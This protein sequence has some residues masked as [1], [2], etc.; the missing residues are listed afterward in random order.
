MFADVKDQ[1]D[2]AREE[3]FGPVISAM[4]F[5]D[6]EDV[7][8]RGNDTEYGLACGVWTRDLKKAHRMTRA[9]RAGMIWVNCYNVQ[10]PAIPFGGYKHSGFGR[11]GGQQHMEEY[12][13]VKS[14]WLNMQ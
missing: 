14:V 6:I 1:M 10:D 13:N 4:P 7:I 12:L 3:I 9:I 11:E 5:D 2:I 8:R